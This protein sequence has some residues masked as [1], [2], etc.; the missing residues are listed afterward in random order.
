MMVI[1][2]INKF[3]TAFSN[4]VPFEAFSNLKLIK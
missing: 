2:S 3:M 1:L 4:D